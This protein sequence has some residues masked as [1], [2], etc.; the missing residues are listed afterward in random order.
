MNVLPLPACDSLDCSPG[1]KRGSAWKNSRTIEN[2]DR[3]YSFELTLTRKMG[4]RESSIFDG[5]RARTRLPGIG[6]PFG[7]V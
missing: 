6:G 1:W 2:I 5:P 3:A 7:L 4:R